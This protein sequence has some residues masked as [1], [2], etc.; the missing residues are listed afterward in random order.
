MSKAY[1]R[2][3]IRR[4]PTTSWDTSQLSDHQQKNPDPLLSPAS[5]LWPTSENYHVIPSNV[6]ADLALDRMFTS[7]ATARLESFDLYSLWTTMPVDA[8]TT[9]Y[10]QAIARDLLDAKARVPILS[11]I[12]GIEKVEQYLRAAAGARQPSG[13]ERWLLD[14]VL[15]YTKTIK[16]VS[17][18]MA[19]VSWS[20]EGLQTFQDALTE[21]ESSERFLELSQSSI[22]VASELSQIRYKLILEDSTI[23]VDRSESTDQ[24][25]RDHLQVLFERFGDIDIQSP[26]IASSYRSRTHI[27]D[28]ILTI[29]ARIF[30]EEFS[31]LAAFAHENHAFV[32]AWI[33]RLERELIYYLAWIEEILGFEARGLAWT[34]PVLNDGP[35]VQ[36]AEALYDLALAHDLQHV[37]TP[38]VT[39][40]WHLDGNES[41]TVV[42]GPNNGGKT[43]YARSVGQLYIVAALGLPVGA[44]DAQ[45]TLAPSVTTIFSE[46]EAADRATGRLEDE[47]LRIQSFFKTAEPESFLIA[48]EIFSSTSVSDAIALGRLLIERCQDRQ[49]RAIIVTF[50]D[51]LAKPTPGVVSL[52]GSSDRVTHQRSYK[53]ERRPPQGRAQALE[54]ALEHGL[55]S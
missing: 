18:Q 4:D 13:E 40:Q 34:L 8:T 3:L 12:D 24:D 5:L 2:E 9:R 10:R 50:V 30:T 28:R 22:R 46:R 37:P 14:A 27:D 33:P 11:F 26:I 52:V 49:L 1:L 48:N 35:G 53:F 54:L 20:S 29:L 32:A 44:S 17:E 21:L 39:N 6:L 7:L 45:I 51:E 43:T 41:I 47:V 15:T 31:D 23:T 16:T 25:Y 38:P 55:I 19:L 36:H 42:T